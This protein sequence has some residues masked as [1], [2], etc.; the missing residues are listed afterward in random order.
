MVVV[1]FKVVIS[2]G[3]VKEFGLE[4]LGTPFIIVF[5]VHLL[6]CAVHLS[7]GYS[8][9]AERV[10]VY[11][12]CTLVVGVTLQF[13]DVSTEERLRQKRIECEGDGLG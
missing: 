3:R 1:K 13:I 4:G 5:I 11:T 7:C 9:Q 6:F 8:A 10:A 12:Y 2:S